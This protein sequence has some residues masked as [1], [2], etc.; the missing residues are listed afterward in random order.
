[1]EAPPIVICQCC[2]YQF[3]PNI[4]QCRQDVD[5]GYVCGDCY[6]KLKWAHAYLKLV[7]IKQCSKLF[8]NRTDATFT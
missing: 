1:M 6:V 3:D 4:E 8:N 2:Y 7:G 5:V